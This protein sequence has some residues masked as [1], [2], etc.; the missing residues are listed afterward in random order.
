[1]KP[2]NR[3]L[4]VQATMFSTLVQ[5][6]VKSDRDRLTVPHPQGERSEEM[7]R[8]KIYPLLSPV[9]VSEGKTEKRRLLLRGICDRVS[10]FEEIGGGD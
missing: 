8:Y 6:N 7:P 3:L 2:T 1:M 10:V 4:F 5:N 9:T